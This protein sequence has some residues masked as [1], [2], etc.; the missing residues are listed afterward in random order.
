VNGQRR[1]WWHEWQPDLWWRTVGKGAGQHSLRTQVGLLDAD[2]PRIRSQ[3]N[4]AS[5]GVKVG[6]P[7]TLGGIGGGGA[8]PT[9]AAAIA[10]VVVILLLAGLLRL[11]L[12]L[13]A[14]LVL[15]LS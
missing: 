15:L 4:C 11:L 3:L 6:G 1:E 8:T 14:L 13:R 2:P 7:R 12:L 10:V 9:A 5:L